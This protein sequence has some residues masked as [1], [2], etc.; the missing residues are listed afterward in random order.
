MTPAE[1]VNTF[2]NATF[3]KPADAEGFL[4]AA[5]PLD[6]GI[7][8]K[9]LEALLA[10]G[11]NANAALYRRKCAV[12]GELGG[13]VQDVSLFV[14]FVRAIKVAD[15]NLRPV[16][17]TLIPKVK[18]VAQYG[19]VVQLL[20]SQDN[21]TR[22]TA[23]DLLV[24]LG[25][26]QAYDRLAEVLNDK[27]HLG[28]L[29]AIEAAG[30]I[31]GQYALPVLQQVLASGTPPERQLAVKLIGDSPAFQKAPQE[32]IPVVVGALNDPAES[33]AVAAITTFCRICSEDQWFDALPPLLDS[34]RVPLVRSAVEGLRRFNSPR[35]IRVLER[36]LR[37]GPNAV[38]NVVLNVLETIA[39]DEVLPPLVDALGSKHLA[40]RNRAVEVLK[41]LSSGGK[42]DV[43]RTIL[44][45]LKSRDV[46]VRRMA[47]EVAKTIKD[48]NAQL[49]PKMLHLLRDEDWWV[50]E[51][52]V[53]VLVE[54]AGRE[55]TR[56]VAQHLQDPSEVVRQF[57]VNVLAR[58]KDPQSLGVLVRAMQSDT[59]WLVRERA[60]EAISSINDPRANPYIE[61][62]IKSAPEYRWAAIKAAMDMKANGLGASVAACLTDTDP[63]VRL[64]ALQCLE[65][66]NDAS[67]AEKV[68]VAANDPEPRNRELARN[69]LG[70][71]NVALLPETQAAGDGL[72][73]LDRVLMTMEKAE[74]DDLLL[75]A[76]K[77]PLMKRMG[78]ISPLSN[79]ELSADQIK[80]LLVPRLT[81]DQRAELAALRDVDFSYEIAAT[82]LRFRAN[83]LQDNGGMAAVFRAIRG[84]I[85]DIKSLGL[86]H[87]MTT[88]GDLKNGLVLIGGPTGSGKSTTL[89]AIINYINET[90]QRHIISLEDPIEAKHLSKKGLVNQREI[91]THTHSYGAALRSTLREDPD[92]ILVGELRDFA[93][94]SFA[95]TAA[96]TGHLVFGTVHTVS[97]D[98]SVDRLV[99]AFPSPQQDQVRTMLAQSLRAVCCQYL[100]KGADDKSRY[101]ATE[102]MINNDAIGSLIRKGKTF[103]IQ[104]VVATSR[105]A[106][107]HLMDA[108][109]M[110]LL[111]D[112]KITPEEAYL[113]ARSKKEFEGFLPT[114]EQALKDLE[115]AAADKGAH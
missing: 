84:R 40:V 60:I 20:S 47:V 41:K 71:W 80:G 45:L 50:R 68:R 37:S 72:S 26:K 86:P 96:E 23:A 39:T 62:M 12:F 32:A 101:M 19:E 61:E 5:V 77:P 14:Q 76:G 25:G 1:I 89:A 111:K 56:H 87:T 36:K 65:K 29:E 99:N 88:L 82:G 74:G 104:S 10:R 21:T 81:A 102:V 93:T 92:V 33:V 38:R 43:T 63:E 42:L 90:S 35:V 2:K 108:S 91:G 66:F 114:N 110:S 13:R 70:V 75:S 115:K 17:V 85:P 113:K 28:R 48:P 4:R 51:R 58:L 55:L 67:L 6:P 95:V 18:Q 11:A 105:E 100:I 73:A 107:M 31:G 16:L 106:G 83:V 79:R 46:N 34:E 30:K 103:Q 64:M 22:R 94:I 49:W 3:E 59:D 7:I 8:S 69:L 112:K 57:S 44:W 27:K 97:V 24:T 9:C 78:T 54:L 15:P 52:I 53:D 98:A 109:L